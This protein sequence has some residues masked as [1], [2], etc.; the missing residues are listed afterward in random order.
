MIIPAEFKDLLKRV[1]RPLEE[2]NP[3]SDEYAVPLEKTTDVLDALVGTPVAILGGDILE[4]KGGRLAYSY[5][6]WYSEKEAGEDPRD[7]AARSQRMA[8]EY[9]DNLKKQGRKNLHV[10]FVYSELG[11]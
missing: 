5:E 9:T 2:I 8:Q 6:N 1:G 11:V 10:V 4:D 3:G 7:F